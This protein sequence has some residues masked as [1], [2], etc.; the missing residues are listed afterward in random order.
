MSVF[1][2]L[3]EGFE[4]A[5]LTCSLILLVPGAAV[6]LAARRSAVPALASFAIGVIGFSWLRFA[7]RGGGYPP[8]LIATALLVVTVVLLLPFIGRSDAAAVPAGFVGGAVAAELWRPCVGSEFG[9]LLNE[10]PERGASGLGLMT[11]FVVGTLSPLAVVGAVHHLVPD[12][13]MGRIEPALAALGG[14]VLG[15]LAIATALGFHDE[16][17]G[18][19]FEWSVDRV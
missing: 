12:K 18:Q 9:Q 10:L 1:S 5:L 14:M 3:A 17:V 4:S 13:V 7:D 6:G 2:L 16:L 15:L 8:L 19:L 11:V